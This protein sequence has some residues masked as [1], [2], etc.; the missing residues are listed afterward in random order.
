MQWCASPKREA[1]SNGGKVSGFRQSSLERGPTEGSWVGMTPETMDNNVNNTF[2][3]AWMVDF[4]VL[5]T[6][7]SIAPF[8]LS[9][10]D[11]ELYSRETNLVF[12]SLG[13]SGPK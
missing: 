11:E 9:P 6:S 5:R 7:I 2:L 12:G 8:S 10:L 1:V 13:L 3:M 4:L